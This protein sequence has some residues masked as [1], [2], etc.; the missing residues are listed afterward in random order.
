MSG[1]RQQPSRRQQG[2]PEDDPYPEAYSNQAEFDRMM[3]G[4]HTAGYNGDTGA[5]ESFPTDSPMGKTLRQE[6]ERGRRRREKE[7]KQKK[8]KT[9]RGLGFVES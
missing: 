9:L 4:A 2:G 8:Q 5:I 1:P 3:R 6:Y 7:E